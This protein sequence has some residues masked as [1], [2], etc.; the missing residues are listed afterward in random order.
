MNIKEKSEFLFSRIG[1]IDDG[2][3]YEAAEYKPLR[4]KSYNF[5]M[6]AACF[7]LIM[8]VAVVSPLLRNLGS[9]SNEVVE[10]P[11]ASLDALLLDSKS[12][13]FETVESP[14]ELT[15]I[16]QASLVWQYEDDGE[17]YVVPLSIGQLN[18]VTKKLGSGEDVGDRSP[19]LDCRVWVLDGKGNVT[20]PYLKEG[21]GNEGCTIF[22]YE[23]EIIPDEELI[24][25]ISEILN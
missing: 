23:A 22:D 25:R 14:E 6:I 19:E 20:S 18:S 1:E 3:V 17:L 2:L 4:K 7:A 21:A 12:E 15:Y 9:M 8:V 10:G 5:A 13:K 11:Y 16:G 24:K